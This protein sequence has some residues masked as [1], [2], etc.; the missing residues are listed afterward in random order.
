MKG[1]S[2]KKS[3]LEKNLSYFS[4]PVSPACHWRGRVSKCDTL[5]TERGR[6]MDKSRA[7]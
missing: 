2:G 3:G 7:D 1:W 5:D 6:E 4:S